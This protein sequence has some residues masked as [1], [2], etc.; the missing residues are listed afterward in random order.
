MTDQEVKD[1][2]WNGVLDMYAGFISQDRERID[3][4]IHK[5]V[6]L[7]DSTERNLA[8]GMKGLNGVRARRPKEDNGPK[9]TRIDAIE[10]VIDIYGDF[11]ICRHYLIVNFDQG[12]P[13][14]EVRNT[15][16]WRSFPEGWR[17]IHN[18]EDELPAK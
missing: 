13:P 3:Q 12:Q 1:Y 8:F 15:G 2:I 6:T 17:I 9:V 5:D 10:P 18:H 4:Y 16:I 7:W 14:Q 11:A